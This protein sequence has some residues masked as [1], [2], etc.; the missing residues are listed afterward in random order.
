MKFTCCDSLH[1]QSAI[2]I[3]CN[4]HT[5]NTQ[6]TGKQGPTHYR[7]CT[8]YTHLQ[9]SWIDNIP[10]FWPYLEYLCHPGVY[11]F[12]YLYT[13]ITYRA[14]YFPLSYIVIKPTSVFIYNNIPVKDHT[15]YV[16]ECIG[17]N[18]RYKKWYR[19]CQINYFTN[20]V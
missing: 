15:P 13:T 2:D 17:Y 18:I 10:R 3:P 19:Q 12:I 8:L 14:T 7:L 6:P 16:W 20:Y 5:R 1:W 9:V 11:L 4:W